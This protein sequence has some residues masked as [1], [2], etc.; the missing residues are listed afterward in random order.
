MPA[1]FRQ[2]PERLGALQLNAVCKIFGASKSDK[3]LAATAAMMIWFRFTLLVYHR[4]EV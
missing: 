1:A 2:F 4:V 3:A